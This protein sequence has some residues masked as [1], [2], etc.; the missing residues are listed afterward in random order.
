[1]QGSDASKWLLDCVDARVVC[2]GALE[3][4]TRRARA[5]FADLRGLGGLA[6]CVPPSLPSS[7]RLL[8]S[9]CLFAV[10]HRPARRPTARRQPAKPRST[11]SPST[12]LF[13]SLVGS[14]V[15]CPTHTWLYAFLSLVYPLHDAPPH[16]PF[17]RGYLCR[18]RLGRLDLRLPQLGLLGRVQLAQ[19]PRRCRQGHPEQRPGRA[20]LRLRFGESLRAGLT[21]RGMLNDLPADASGLTF[22][23]SRAARRTASPTSRL[24]RRPR[25][26]RASATVS[27]TSSRASSPRR[28]ALLRARARKCHTRSAS[29]RRR[30]A[31]K[32]LVPVTATAR[33]PSSTRSR[34]TR[35]TATTRRRARSVS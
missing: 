2:C 23:A 34:S 1:M 3:A 14:S 30:R 8:S 27:T 33:R 15:A 19:R 16:P 5:L 6:V 13:L 21:T 18:P 26:A 11:P 31:N 22:R 10:R 20:A 12:F 9:L 29:T 7:R 35:M 4:A 28:A 17:R 32:P 24:A 25:T